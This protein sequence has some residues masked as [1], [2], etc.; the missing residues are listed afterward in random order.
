MKPFLAAV[1]LTLPFASGTAGAAEIFGGVYVHDVDTGLTKS[2]I[3]E[4]AD[5]ELGW[6]GDRIGFLKAIGSP[7]P[8]AFVSVNS[9]GNT[10]FAAAGISWEIG[11]RVYVRPG[12]G[13]AVHTGPGE[14][15]PGDDRIDFGSRVLF[16]PE[17]GIGTRV[18]DRLSVEASW[19]H[20]SHA[21]LFGPQNPGLDTIGV[22]IN[23]RLR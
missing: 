8:Q 13:L 15:V 9:A 3:E 22:R 16:A 6:R 4:G 2:G 23:Y 20:L 17:I 21:Q 11:G 7:R 18:S 5:F 1:A 12:I 10:H 14:V 19:V